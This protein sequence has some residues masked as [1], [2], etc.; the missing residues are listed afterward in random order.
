M[1][2]EYKILDVKEDW[3]DTENALNVLANKGWKVI[4]SYS[5][6]LWIILE[7]EIKE[8]K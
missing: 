3:Q 4:T 8:E 7:R 5:R 1:K 6:G 2:I